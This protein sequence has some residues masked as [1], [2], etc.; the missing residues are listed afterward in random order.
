MP[1]DD[2]IE[3]HLQDP[4]LGALVVLYEIDMSDLGGPTLN[5]TPM[6]KDGTGMSS[7]AFGG[8]T[9]LPFP[10]MAEGFAWKSAEAPPQP[11]V[12]VANINHALTSYVTQYDHLVGAKFTRIRTFETF[13]DEGDTPDSNAHLPLDIFRFERKIIHNEQMIQWELASWIDQQGVLLPKRMLVRD[14]CP[15]VYRDGSSGSF[16]YSNATCPY[17]GGS[18]FDV[19]DD[20]VG[21]I[22]E[23]ICS[24]KLSGCAA[25]FGTAD[26][27][28][29]GFPG[30]PKFRVQ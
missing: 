18:Y 24:H 9:Y 17:T 25:R 12:S 30:V 26:I 19:N 16:D 20:A 14:Y 29:G 4:S 7:V 5:Y 10:I 8:T 2:A 1:M 22:A 13:L 23:D 27:P 3:A 6:S 28:F 21:T 15:L 11:K